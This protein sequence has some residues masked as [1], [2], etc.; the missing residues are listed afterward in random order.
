MAS[1]FAGSSNRYDSEVDGDATPLGQRSPTNCTSVVCWLLT[2][3]KLQHLSDWFRSWVRTRF[4]LL[5]NV[6]SSVDAQYYTSLDLE[7]R[8]RGGMVREGGRHL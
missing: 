8:F 1:K 6:A 5:G 2:S 4:A 3:V 7:E